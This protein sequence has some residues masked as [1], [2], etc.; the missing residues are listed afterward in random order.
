MS[1]KE[2]EKPSWISQHIDWISKHVELYRQDPDKGHMWDSAA[3]GGP[4]LLPTLLLSTKGRKS[5]ETRV[6][7]LIYG[8]HGDSHV[9]IASKGGTPKHPSWYLNLEADPEC[10]IQVAH[11]HSQTVARIAK[12]EEREALWQQLATVYPPYDDYQA[13]TS[14]EIPVVVLDPRN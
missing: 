13:A 6:L 7:P 11:D 2:T 3:V 4:G 14:R 1:E 12:G 5:G 10:E 9:V 8:K